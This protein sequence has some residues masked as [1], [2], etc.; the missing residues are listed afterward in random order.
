MRSVALDDFVTC[1]DTHSF[2]RSWLS[3]AAAHLRHRRSEMGHSYYILYFTPL[4]IDAR[5]FEEARKRFFSLSLLLLF[6]GSRLIRTYSSFSLLFFLFVAIGSAFVDRLCAKVF[7]YVCVCK[8]VVRHTGQLIVHFS[9]ENVEKQETEIERQT[10]ICVL[11]IFGVVP[12]KKN[13]NNND[14]NRRCG[15]RR[16]LGSAHETYSMISLMIAC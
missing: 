11:E 15:N 2:T 5:C 7:I 9:T 4:L 13:N 6:V 16:I 10:L 1:S 8:V 12:T 14:N 3:S